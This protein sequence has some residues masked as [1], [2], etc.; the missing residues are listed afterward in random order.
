MLASLLAYSESRFG[1]VWGPAVYELGT[2]IAPYAAGHDAAA[3]S[4]APWP[5]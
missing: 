1:P 2:S 5:S 3:D 4:T